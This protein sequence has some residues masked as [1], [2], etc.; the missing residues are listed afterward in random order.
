MKVGLTIGYSPARIRGRYPASG[1]SGADSLSVRS[2]QPEAIE[3]MAK[4]AQLN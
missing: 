2:R 3:V 4:A 1:A